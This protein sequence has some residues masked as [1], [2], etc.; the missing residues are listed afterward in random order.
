MKDI[1]KI[2]NY[3]ENRKDTWVCVDCM[4]G[5]LELEK[6]NAAEVVRELGEKFGS[7]VLILYQWSPYNMASS[8][9]GGT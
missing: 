9:L 3:F 1:K 8:S 4:C 6:I 7:F 2:G 5:D